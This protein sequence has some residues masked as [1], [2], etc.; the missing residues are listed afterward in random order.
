[1]GVKV[2]ADAD[3][4][5]DLRT[6]VEEVL[7][8]KLGPFG[9]KAL[10]VSVGETHGG[11]PRLLVEAHFPPGSFA[12]AG[13]VRQV[14]R[15]QTDAELELFSLIRRVLPGTIPQIRLRIPDPPFRAGRSKAA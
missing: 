12:S 13:A 1:M 9:L 7:S 2:T 8:R 6:A 15:H 11:H 5:P 3:V 4:S 10:V 14:V